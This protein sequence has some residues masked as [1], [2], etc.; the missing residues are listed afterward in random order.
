MKPIAAAFVSLSMFATA[1]AHA[2]AVYR[3]GSV[4]SQTPCAQAGSVVEVGDARSAGQQAEARRIAADERQLA[5]QM[6]HDR[7]AEQQAIRPAGATSLSGPPAKLASTVEHPRKK[8]RATAKPLPTT[9][10]VVYQPASRKRRSSG[11]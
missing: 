3:C 5:A 2:Q 7:L 10:F 4:Y 8:K 11:A 6:R 1:G 9:D